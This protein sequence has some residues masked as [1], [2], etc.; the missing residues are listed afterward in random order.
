MN[1]YVYNFWEQIVVYSLN[2]VRHLKRNLT[3]WVKSSMVM[4]QIILCFD[5]TNTLASYNSGNVDNLYFPP[6][7]GKGSTWYTLFLNAESN[8]EPSYW[9]STSYC[10]STY[11]KIIINRNNLC[12]RK[13]NTESQ[14]HAIC[15]I[16]DSEYIKRDIL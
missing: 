8:H 11:W 3:I 6:P 5:S 13:C 1:E 14:K 2:S 16:Y 12:P 7:L 10:H 9:P 4:D 15:V